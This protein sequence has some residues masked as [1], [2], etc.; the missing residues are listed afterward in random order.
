MIKL[1]IISDIH[2]GVDRTPK[3]GSSAKRLFEEFI[4]WLD[5]NP[6]DLLI[7][8]GDRIQDMDFEKD[9]LLETEV[10]AWF[11]K[12]NIRKEFLL[13]NHD[14]NILSKDDNDKIFDYDF[15]SHSLDL[16][17]FHLVFFMP[18][19][20]LNQ[21]SG[22]TLDDKSIEWLRSDLSSSQL[23]TIIFSHVPLDNGS[24]IGNYYFDPS[25]KPQ[26]AYYPKETSDRLREVI[27]NS[28]KVILCVNGHAHW[29]TYHCI[30]GIHHVTLPSLTESFCTFPEISSSWTTLTVKDDIHIKVYGNLPIEYKFPIKKLNQ[31]WLSKIRKPS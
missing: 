29:N 4:F 3:V 6:H 10:A 8:L 17:N 23:P 26:H 25:N 16:N 22:F 31:H 7:D 27:I 24:M 19:T 9:L 21:N 28:E 1:A 20:K 2:H 14:I 11:K 12:I 13:G 5:K 15:S 30:D 18:D